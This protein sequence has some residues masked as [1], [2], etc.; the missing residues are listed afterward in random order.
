[1]PGLDDPPALCAECRD[2]IRVF[3]AEMIV[4][5]EKRAA[6]TGAEQGVVINVLLTM[7]ST[8]LGDNL[9]ELIEARQKEK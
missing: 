6:E 2:A 7:Q 1:M 9:V 3:I 4:A 8:L 5:V